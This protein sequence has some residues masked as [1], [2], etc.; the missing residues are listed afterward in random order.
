GLREP[1]L[2][3][4]IGTL[5]SHHAEFLPTGAPN[6]FEIVVPANAA[7]LAVQTRTGKSSRTPLEL[8]LYDCTSG[9]CFSYDLA[10]PASMSQR[11]VVRRPQAGRW[12]AAVNAAPFPTAQGGFL[13]DAIIAVGSP[14][15]SSESTRPLARGM[16]WSERVDTYAPPTLQTGKAP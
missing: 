10:F 16:R 4:S 5:E 11:L 12:V 7:A 13:I 15:R 8:Y 9:E 14:R 2:E 1:V 6:L 3:T